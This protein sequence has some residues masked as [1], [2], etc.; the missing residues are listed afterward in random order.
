VRPF[1]LHPATQA[2]L[3]SKR[4]YDILS[5]VATQ[6]TFSFTVMPFVL[7]TLPASLTAWARVYFYAILTVGASLAIFASP[8]QQTLRRQLE[9]RAANAG[10]VKKEDRNTLSRTNSTDS[11]HEHPVHGLSSDPQREID[12][13]VGELRSEVKRRQ[14]AIAAARKEKATGAGVRPAS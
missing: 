2:P 11:V 6:T 10:V 5:Y 14:T 8:A 4:Y 3:P 1:F 13:M 7:L 9:V 12:E